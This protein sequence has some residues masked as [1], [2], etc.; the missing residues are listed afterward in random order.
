M[1]I[2]IW[3]LATNIFNTSKL[4]LLFSPFLASTFIFGNS[5]KNVFEGLIFTFGMHPFDVGDRVIVDGMQMK[6]RMMNFLTTV[7]FKYDTQEEVIYPNSVLAS[8]SISNLDIVPDQGDSLD[9]AIDVE[10][11][12]EDIVDIENK[13]K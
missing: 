12:L 8:K 11:P 1:M 4:A 9:F 3:L 2:V 6:V 7:F 13:I 10:T 5:C